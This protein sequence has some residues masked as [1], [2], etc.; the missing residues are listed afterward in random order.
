MIRDAPVKNLPVV[1]IE[2]R[3]PRLDIEWD[4]TRK[5][6]M[7]T[8]RDFGLCPWLRR[9][10]GF[11]SGRLTLGDSGLGG[12]EALHTAQLGRRIIKIPLVNRRFTS[13]AYFAPS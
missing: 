5:A 6:F 1:G 9:S 10:L 4:Q 8:L 2:W 7:S 3:I 13:P 12:I 11:V